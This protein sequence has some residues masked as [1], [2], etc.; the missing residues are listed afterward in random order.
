MNIK[1]GDSDFLFWGISH[2]ELRNIWKRDMAKIL[3][4]V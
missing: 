2:K 4:L 1:E 3:E